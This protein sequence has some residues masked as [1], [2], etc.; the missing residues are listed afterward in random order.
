MLSSVL[1]TKHAVLVNVEIMRAFVR[2]RQILAS[3]AELAHKLAALES[4]TRN[5]RSCSMRYA[6]SWLRRSGRGRALLALLHGSQKSSL[7]ANRGVPRAMVPSIAAASTRRPH[8][9]VLLAVSFVASVCRPLM[10]PL[11]NL[12]SLFRLV[13]LA[14]LAAPAAHG[15][16]DEA[17]LDLLP[18]QGNVYM[19][20]G[21]AGNIAVQI[22]DD[23]VM[24]VNAMG[25]GFAE[26]IAA[27]IGEATPAP[28]R[29][30]INT[31]WDLHHTGGNAEV[32]ALGMFGS[33][34]SLAPGEAPG[35]SLVAHENV[36][37]RL[38]ELS[39]AEERDPYPS[40][41]IPRDAYI[42]PLRDI[43]FNGEPVFVMH[44]PNAHSDGDSIV[45]FRK[46]DTIAV[47][48]L[49]TPGRYPVIDVERG[50]N[51][52]GLIRALNHV[53]DLA[54]PQRL[55]DGGTRII[56]GSGRLCNEADVV[57]YRNMVVIVRDRVRD[58]M[59]KGMSLE[60]IKAARLTRDYDTEYEGAGEAFVES[61]YESL[62][63]VDRESAR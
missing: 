31:S 55:Q 56:P 21:A 59:K 32:A 41:G 45:L 46:S 12:L 13:C 48:D 29:Y 40:A 39:S 30:I 2:L 53:L 34:P 24:L 38:T 25:Q 15:Q 58:L 50:G 26:R 35:A 7:A 11:P 42:L 16:P 14:S 62:A 54:V 20:H 43:W 28:I 22:G 10:K 18:V 3:N 23:G 47:G 63:A 8:S 9:L 27:A 61:I 4:M 6:S 17:P 5:S 36:M 37:L 51:V 52:Q 57:E 49:F 33:T 60:E 19:L 44:E 1:R